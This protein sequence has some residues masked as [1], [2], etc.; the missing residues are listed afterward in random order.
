MLYAAILDEIEA[1]GYQAHSKRAH[2]S[3]LRKLS[4][5]PAIFFQVFSPPR[6]RRVM[7]TDRIFPKLTN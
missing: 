4:L 5:L 1:I 7:E 2:T 6:D 3:G